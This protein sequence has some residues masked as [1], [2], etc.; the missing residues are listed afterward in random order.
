MTDQNTFPAGLAEIRHLKMDLGNQGAGG[1]K[2]L[3][4]LQLGLFPDLLGNTM[5]AED[6]DRG[7]VAGI[8]IR[9]L[10]QFFHEYG[11]AITQVVHHELVMYDFVPYIDRGT[12]DI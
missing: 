5:G 8:D 2:H 6:D 12:K 11:A 10:V 3:E 9:N 7:P 1:I 4:S